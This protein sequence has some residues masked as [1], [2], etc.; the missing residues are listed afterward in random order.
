MTF[1]QWLREVDTALTSECGLS[2][3]DLPDQPWRDW[4]DSD[5]TPQDAAQECLDNEGYYDFAFVEEGE[6]M[7]YSMDEL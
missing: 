3:L 5:M 6:E 7:W 2:Y 1:E 4:F